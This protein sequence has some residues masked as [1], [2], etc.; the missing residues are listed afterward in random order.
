MAA[1]SLADSGFPFSNNAIS[2]STLSCSLLL[3]P[4]IPALRTRVTE[5]VASGLPFLA[6]LRRK[7]KLVKSAD[8]ILK[9]GQAD[10]DQEQ[11]KLVQVWRH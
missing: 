8:A 11:R 3:M 9:K 4:D 10:A 1:T 6:T 5:N 7:G 2:R